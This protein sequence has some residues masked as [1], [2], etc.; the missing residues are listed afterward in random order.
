MRIPDSDKQSQKTIKKK[1]DV[2]KQF[3][4][5]MNVNNHLILILLG[6]EK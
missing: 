4:D 1:Y 6:I 2:V 3:L 5:W